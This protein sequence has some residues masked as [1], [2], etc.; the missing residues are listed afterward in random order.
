LCLVW[1]SNRWRCG[2]FHFRSILLA[3]EPF[4]PFLVLL[5]LCNRTCRLDSL[6]YETLVL[7]D[8]YYSSQESHSFQRASTVIFHKPSNCRSHKFMFGHIEIILWI[9]L[10]LEVLKGLAGNFLVRVL[11]SPSYVFAVYFT[12]DAPR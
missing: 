6:K 7:V 8:D 11:L 10:Y 3:Y 2:F 12:P 5:Y 1:V 4:I 9:C